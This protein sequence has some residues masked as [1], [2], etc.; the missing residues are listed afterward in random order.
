[1]TRVLVV[2][3]SSALRQNICMSL[4]QAGFTVYTA[5][6][7]KEALQASEYCRFDLVLCDGDRPGIQASPLLKKIS[8]VPSQAKAVLVTMGKLQPKNSDNRLWISLSLDP[9]ELLQ[10]VLGVMH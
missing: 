10:R 9:D 2:E 5:A 7:E 3:D 8:A 1:M 6:T 4:K